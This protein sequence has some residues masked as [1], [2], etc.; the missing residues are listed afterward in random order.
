M[1]DILLNKHGDVRKVN[2]DFQFVSGKD[3][4]VQQIKQILK[5]NKKEWFR[6]ENYGVSYENLQQK[7]INEDLIKDTIRDGIAQCSDDITIE[8]IEIGY[9]GEHMRL[10]YVEFKAYFSDG[11]R[12]DNIIELNL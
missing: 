3:E 7:K 5:T 12:Y 6:N 2:G 4:V 1:Q 10:L 8:S 11:E 9:K